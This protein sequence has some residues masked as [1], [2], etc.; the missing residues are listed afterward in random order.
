MRLC[1]APPPCPSGMYTGGAQVGRLMQA[2]FLFSFFFH[3][4]AS[5][6]YWSSSIGLG[7]FLSIHM[8]PMT[9]PEMISC[10]PPSAPPRL[11]RS[12]QVLHFEMQPHRDTVPWGIKTC[13]LRRALDSR[14]ASQVKTTLTVK[15]WPVKGCIGSHGVQAQSSGNCPA[16]TQ[17]SKV[18]CTQ[19]PQSCSCSSADLWCHS[20]WWAYTEVC[21]HRVL[22][23][24]L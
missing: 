7:Q 12:L 21:M 10:Q 4:G 15:G 11:Q 13:N 22:I 24:A 3:A 5:L 14:L 16:A 2:R 23:E 20:M 8:F 19:T 9:L 17:Q 18:L 6:P 1:L